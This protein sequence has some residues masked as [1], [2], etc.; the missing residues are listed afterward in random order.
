MKNGPLPGSSSLAFGFG[1]VMAEYKW[2]PEFD[3]WLDVEKEI[4][5]VGS[6]P[7]KV[8]GRI[9]VHLD[10][11]RP[12]RTPNRMESHVIVLHRI[13]GVVGK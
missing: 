10:T 13:K 2:C 3:K 4:P 6:T 7:K 1:R 12:Q 8:T 5:P 9:I 11:Q